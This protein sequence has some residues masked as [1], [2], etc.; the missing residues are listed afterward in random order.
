[1]TSKRGIM[2]K[3]LEGILNEKR[4]DFAEWPQTQYSF[5]DMCCYSGHL[6]DDDQAGHSVTC[7]KWTISFGKGNREFLH[8]SMS[9]CGLLNVQRQKFL[10]LSP[11]GREV[12]FWGSL[13]YL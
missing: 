9:I 7:I 12:I 10:E 6:T 4:A 5:P 1:M 3:K 2:A 8:F 13:F 11:P